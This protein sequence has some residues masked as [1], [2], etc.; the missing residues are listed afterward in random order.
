M[1]TRKNLFVGIDPGEIKGGFGIIDHDGRYVLAERWCRKDPR[2]TYNILYKYK[3]RVLIVYLEDINLPQAAPL[4]NQFSGGSN[5]LINS[6]IWQGWLIALDLPYVLV[7]PQTWQAAHGLHHWQARQKK[8]PAA[9]SPVSRARDLWP[10][11]PLQ[12]QADDGKGVGLLLS[13]FARRDHLAGID[14]QA[15]RDQA[16]EKAKLKKQKIRQTKKAQA[17]LIGE[18][19]PW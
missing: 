16:S 9:P 14:R 13:D 18:N 8:N 11:A 1:E 10:V 15:V 5:L 12:F 17:R 3:D 4:G 6:G 19:S 7:R 2:A